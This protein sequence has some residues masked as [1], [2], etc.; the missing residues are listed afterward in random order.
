MAKRKPKHLAR[1]EIV[2]F[3]LR[4]VAHKRFEMGCGILV[5]LCALSIGSLDQWIWRKHTKT[6]WGAWGC[7][8]L[9]YFGMFRL[10]YRTQNHSRTLCVRAPGIES[11]YTI[12]HALEPQHPIF[13]DLVL[14]L[15]HSAVL[16]VLVVFCLWVYLLKCMEAFFKRGLFVCSLNST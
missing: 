11:D 6:T 9:S 15:N 8:F 16:V 5:I 13:R 1:V 14:C 10:Q 12:Q 4:I 3:P 7:M 2:T